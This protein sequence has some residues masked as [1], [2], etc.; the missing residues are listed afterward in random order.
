MLSAALTFGLYV[1]GHFNADLRNFETVVD[2]RPVGVRWLAVLYYVLPNLAPFDVKAAGRARA[3]G[4]GRL[5]AAERRRTRVAVRAACCWSARCSSSRAGTSNDG[6]RRRRTAAYAGALAALMAAAIGLQLARDRVYPAGADGD[7]FLYVRSGTR[8]WPG[9]ACRTMRCWPIC[10]GFAP[11]STTAAIGLQPGRVEHGTDAAV[12]AARPHDVARSAVQHRVPVRGDLPG[13]GLPGRRGAARSGHRAPREGRARPCRTSGST[14]HDIGFVYYWCL[15]DYG[16]AASWF[17]RGAAQPGAPWWLRSLRGRHADQGRR[18]RG[19]A[20]H[21]AEHPRD[22]R[23]RLAAAATRRR[24]CSQ[25]DALDEIDGLQAAVR[26][27]EGRLGRYAGLLGGARGRAPASA[28][29]RSI[30]PARRTSWIHAPGP[31][32]LS[33]GIHAVSAAGRARRVLLVIG[34]PIS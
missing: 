17:L 7:R 18:S 3:A 13:R 25:L 21:V 28:A 2:S 1:V 15:H 10:T 24:G 34:E 31:C 9:S 19:V 12:P 22:G 11:F 30:R 8:A 27:F 4:A 29:C 14:C 26:A 16:R 23:E 32:R 20:L 5:P 6:R 33:R